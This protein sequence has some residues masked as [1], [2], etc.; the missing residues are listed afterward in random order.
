MDDKILKIFDKLTNES[1]L[2]SKYCKQNWV[3]NLD[4]KNHLKDQYYN[5]Y[6]CHA[7]LVSLDDFL[8]QSQEE[9]Q[10]FNENLRLEDPSEIGRENL[11]EVMLENEINDLDDELDYKFLNSKIFNLENE[12]SFLSLSLYI[13]SKTAAAAAAAPSAVGNDSAVKKRLRR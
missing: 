12:N 4:V 9:T 13:K 7:R 3:I 5:S 6:S 2:T 10:I 1:Y 11:E 8:N